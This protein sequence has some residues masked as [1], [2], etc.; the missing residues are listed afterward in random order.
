MTAGKDLADLSDTALLRRA[1]RDPDAFAEFY[2]RHA[3]RLYSGLLR[4]LA[5]PEAALDL[6]AETFAQA[7]LSLDRF[8]GRHGQSG[9]AWLYAIA[10]NLVR[11][12]RAGADRE[13]R[14][15]ERL[16]IELARD[17]AETVPFPHGGTLLGSLRRALTLIPLDQ[18][19]AVELRVVG[20]QTYDAVA[21]DLGCTPVA[22]RIR[23]YRGLRALQ[24]L[25]RGET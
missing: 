6:T 15:C 13:R 8:R 3:R 7:L 17:G 19:R 11:R 23:V 18:R 25:M 9:S 4:D 16:Q 21:S 1:R 22:A 20:E 24:D 2:D 5:D 14:A 10:R 12:H